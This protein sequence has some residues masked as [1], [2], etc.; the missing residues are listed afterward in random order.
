LRDSKGLADL[1]VLIAR[2][3]REVHVAELVGAADLVVG[4]HD[5]LADDQAI[6]SYRA[7]LAGLAEEE[8]DAH[9]M[10]D[11]ERA[12]RARA[13][14][15]ELVDHLSSSLGLG[16]RARAADDWA[17]RARKAVRSRVG[18]TLKRIDA[19]HPALGKHLRASVRTGAFCVYDPPEPVDWQL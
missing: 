12:A 14:Y 5:A 11:V 4:T 7:R 3:G 18:S 19:Q 15:E 17:E 8:D 10:G 6:A 16:G 13:E 1:A 2:V 9:A